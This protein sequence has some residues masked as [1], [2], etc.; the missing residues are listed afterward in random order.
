[1]PPLLR[2]FFTGLLISFLGS[3]P[4]ATM[5][6]AAMQIAVSDT[7]IAAMLFSLGSLLVEMFYVRLSLVALSWISHQR[8]LFRVLEYVTLIIVL[9]LAVAEF[10]AA[11]QPSE[12][13]N[14]VLSSTLPKFILGALMCALSPGQ[15]PFWLG[16]STVLF[17]KKILQPKSSFYNFYILG[18]G[19]GTFLGNC[20]FIF[21][22]MLIANTIN[23]NQKILHWIIGAIFLGTA[24][25]QAVKMIMRKGPATLIAPAGER[26]M[27]MET[28][29]KRIKKDY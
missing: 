8:K 23:T 15:I 5:N 28:L 13:K 18:I 7:I 14:I 10:Y 6:V 16:W 19:I 20:I 22:G 21:G 11:S 26:L 2:I 27:Q 24:L 3:L 17:S 12:A 29:L 9:A 25:Y 4:L 1:M